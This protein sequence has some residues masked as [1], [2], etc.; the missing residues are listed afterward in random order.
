MIRSPYID[1]PHPSQINSACAST[2]AVAFSCM[3]GGYPYF[4]GWAPH[5]A[6]NTAQCEF[7]I[8]E[9]VA[10]TAFCTAMLVP[11][12]WMPGDELKRRGPRPDAEVYGYYMLP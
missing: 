7:T 11:E 6:E 2:V 10:G 4:R 5:P 12:R 9:T 3:S 1:Q 8:A